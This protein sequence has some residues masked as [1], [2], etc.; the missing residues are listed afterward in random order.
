ML[1]LINGRER[2]TPGKQTKSSRERV[3]E[4]KKKKEEI[5]Q[6]SRVYFLFYFFYF[7]QITYL[8]QRQFSQLRSKTLDIQILFLPPFLLKSIN[9]T[10]R[11]DYFF[12]F[13]LKKLV[14][15]PQKVMF[16]EPKIVSSRKQSVDWI[17]FLHSKVIFS[18]D[19]RNQHLEIVYSFVS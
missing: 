1:Y 17:N 16:L 12:G 3:K 4:E 14:K 6:Q 7:L 2:K 9:M 10:D 8:L 5:L 19:T 18:L 13:F 11:S 15:L